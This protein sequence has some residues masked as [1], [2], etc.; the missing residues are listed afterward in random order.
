M[1]IEDMAAAVAKWAS[2]QPLV[3]KVYLFGSRA[4]GTHRSD[5]DLDI[6]VEIF[7]LTGDS[8]PLATWIGESDRLEASIAGIVP[9]IIDLDW[10]GG[11]AETPLIHQALDRSSLVV[12]TVQA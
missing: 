7:P 2:T 12:Y 8:S 11:E 4:R 6:A 3:R 5:S 1:N 9:V 10:Y